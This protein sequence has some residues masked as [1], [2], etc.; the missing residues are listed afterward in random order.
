MRLLSGLIGGLLSG[1]LGGLPVGLTFGLLYG[2]IYG[3]LG[4][5]IYGLLSGLESRTIVNKTHVP[6]YAIWQ[7]GKNRL[8]FGLVAGLVAGLVFELVAGLVAGLVF[9]LFFGLRY[10]GDAFIQHWILRFLLWHYG[11]MPAPWQYV[12]F[13]DYAVHRILL[14][15][16]GGGWIFIHRMIME[17]IAQLDDAFIESLDEGL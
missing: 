10:G 6:N 7:S 15:R 2:L 17:H 13:L 1:L 8:V 11:Y 14:R 12:K 4:G 5:L 16:V 9:G 3:L